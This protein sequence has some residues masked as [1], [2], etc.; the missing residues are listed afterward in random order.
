MVNEDRDGMVEF[1][2][3]SQPPQCRR[4]D[5]ASSSLAEVQYRTAQYSTVQYSTMTVP[6]R[7]DPPRGEGV[8]VEGVLAPGPE[9]AVRPAAFILEL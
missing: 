6:G 4:P 9:L 5:T 2:N 1:S 3:S 7:G 8:A